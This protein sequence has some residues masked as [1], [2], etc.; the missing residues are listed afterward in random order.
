MSDSREVLSVA[1]INTYYGTS[2]VLRSVSL[3]VTLGQVA[4][5][6]GRN[7]SG[8]STIIRSIIGFTPPRAGT[9]HLLGRPIHG[10]FPDEIARLGVGLVPQ[11]RRIFPNL[12][13]LE[14]LLL[15]RRSGS[16]AWTLDRI[17]SLFPILKE[18]ARQSGL[19]LSGGEQQMLAIARAL[20]GG[21]I[22]L[23]L[24]DEPSE[25]LGP[26]IVDHLTEVIL[27]L[28][29]AGISILLA[30][31]NLGLALSVADQAYV[32]SKG[33]VVFKGTPGQL[34]DDETVRERYFGI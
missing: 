22:R 26:L 4:C 18:R 34:C 29:R 11:G 14:N 32:L 2:H 33:E 20:V 3:G 5:L 23:L 1:G 8:K 12:T 15:C 28:K 27:D 19:S 13:V 31:H 17:F 9:I 25:G 24:M 21:N 30:E 16:A 10:L 6:L 7:G